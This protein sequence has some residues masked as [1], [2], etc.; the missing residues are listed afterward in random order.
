MLRLRA[1]LRRA[2]RASIHPGVQG[3]APQ[4]RMFCATDAEQLFDFINVHVGKGGGAQDFDRI[5]RDGLAR[6]RVLVDRASE[7]IHRQDVFTM[8][9]D[10][11]PVQRCIV[12]A[13]EQ[14]IKYKTKSII[15]VN[16]APGTRKSV[17]AL[18]AFGSPLRRN[19]ST[20]FASGSAA[21]T[22]GMR[23]LLGSD[24]ASLVRFTDFF[25]NTPKIRSMFW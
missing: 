13:L 23:Q 6:S 22:Y 9:D 10:Q 19:Y 8:L 17:I 11:I 15:L 21:F 25:G 24:L 4:A 7:L 3:C 14:A 5:Q 20:F 16:G 12:A 1:Q 2:R 18:D